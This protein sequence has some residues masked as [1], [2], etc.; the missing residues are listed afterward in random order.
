MSTANQVV[1]VTGSSK[2]IGLEIA[3][4]LAE[5]GAMVIVHGPADDEELQQAFAQ[6]RAIQPEAFKIPCDLIDSAA[7]QG[8]F[9]SIEKRWQGLDVLINNAVYQK[10]SPFLQ[11]TEQEWDHMLTINLKAPFLCSQLAARMMIKRGGGRIINIGSVHEFQ[12][13]RNYAPYSTSKGGLLMLTKCMAL[14]L[15][16]HRILVNQITPGAIATDLTDPQRQEKLNSA[17][18]LGRV[19]QKRDIAAMVRYLVS[20][21][22]NYITGSSFLVDGGLT[23]GFCAS[24][25][26]L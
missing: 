21:K 4:T 9:D 13:R 16:P 8:M 5:D 3:R 12:A 2:G 7:I 23:L 24:R 19:G 14:E 15:A 1:L 18:P 20:E 6:V 22:A 26:D 11:I 25:P 10:E 17:I